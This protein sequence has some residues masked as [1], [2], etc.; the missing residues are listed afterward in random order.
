MFLATVQSREFD[1]RFTGQLKH[2]L[3]LVFPMFADLSIYPTR[4]DYWESSAQIL[5]K[6]PDRGDDSGRI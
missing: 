1:I 3:V 6:R 2:D 4:S 5:R